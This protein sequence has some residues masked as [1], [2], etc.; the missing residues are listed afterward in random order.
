VEQ[1]T[2]LKRYITLDMQVMKNCGLSYT[3][4]IFLDNIHFLSNNDTGYCFAKRTVLAEYVDMTTRGLRKLIDRLID[5]GYLFEHPETKHLKTTESWL[6][7]QEVQKSTDAELSSP[8]DPEPSSSGNANSVPIKPELSSPATIKRETKG[9]KKKSTYLQDS[10]LNE[11]FHEYLDIRKKMKAPVTDNVIARLLNK[12]FD[13][14]AK[15]HSME[16]VMNN[17]ITGGWKDFYEPKHKAKAGP[18][19]TKVSN[20]IDVMHRFV[21]GGNNAQ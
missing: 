15:G 4:W 21:E 12:L 17:A 20:G 8:S 6:K 10:H 2:K 11:L 7:I 5:A 9:E 14:Q 16:D 13:Y 1:R 19:G 3:E 18:Y